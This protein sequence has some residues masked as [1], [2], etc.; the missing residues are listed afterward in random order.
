[1]TLLVS[2]VSIAAF[3]VVFQ[4]MQIVP[5]ARR[6][7]DVARRSVGAMRDP[8]LADEAR[9]AAVQRGSIQLLGAFVSIA[10]R[11]LVAVGAAWLPIYLTDKAGLVA[12]ATIYALLARWDVILV[13]TAIALFAYYVCSRV[14]RG[15]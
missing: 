7:I 12:R 2:A 9:E 6:A 10:L 11:S 13:V 4:I 15:K 5:A 14:W 8:G 3:L 1:M